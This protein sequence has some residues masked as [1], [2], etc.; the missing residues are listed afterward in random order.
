[1]VVLLLRLVAQSR[2]IARDD[3]N[4]TAAQLRRALSSTLS[5]GQFACATHTVLFRV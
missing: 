4:I 3:E 1:M 5:V 2:Q